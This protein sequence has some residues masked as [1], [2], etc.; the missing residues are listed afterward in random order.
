M[1]FPKEVPSIVEKIEESGLFSRHEMLL[2]VKCCP[3]VS[4]F[5]ASTLQRLKAIL[6]NKK[7]IG[8][9]ERR[10]VAT[11]CMTHLSH[12]IFS[13]IVW[14]VC[15]CVGELRRFFWRKLKHVISKSYCG[16]NFVKR[17]FHF[18]EDLLIRVRSRSEIMKKSRSLGNP[19]GPNL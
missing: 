18:L 11:W 16:D 2:K 12:T 7:K 10:L 19:L 17:N 1:H 13:A 3:Q 8:E 6:H 14:K 4:T 9:R 5:F 15:P